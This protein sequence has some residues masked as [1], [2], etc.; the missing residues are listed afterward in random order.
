[1]IW[2][3]VGTLAIGFYLHEWLAF[4]VM[5]SIIVPM[6]IHFVADWRRLQKECKND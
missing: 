2:I 6:D 1:M 3:N 5:A 4:A